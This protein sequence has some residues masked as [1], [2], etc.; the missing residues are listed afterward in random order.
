MLASLRALLVLCDETA[1][2]FVRGQEML[3][4]LKA[5]FD[6]AETGGVVGRIAND[7]RRSL[8]RAWWRIRR[9]SREVLPAGSRCALASGSASGAPAI[10]AHSA[11]G[12]LG[13][14]DRWRR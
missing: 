10:K 1:E 12:G 9:R 14:A 11:A 4:E 2:A 7:V 3:E 8:R 13:P 5:D 6:R